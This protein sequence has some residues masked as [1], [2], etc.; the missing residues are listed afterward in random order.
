MGA[1]ADVWR[2]VRIDTCREGCPD[3]AAPSDI[4]TPLSVSAKLSPVPT[5][6][7]TYNASYWTCVT[8]PDHSEEDEHALGELF[9]Y[10]CGTFAACPALKVLE[11][12]A[13][14]HRNE[15]AQRLSTR[16]VQDLFA[17]RLLELN[18]SLTIADGLG[19]FL[20]QQ[21]FIEKWSVHW[22][23][24][25]FGVEPQVDSPL[26]H[27]ALPNVHTLWCSASQANHVLRIRE[28]IMRLE[29]TDVNFPSLHLLEHPYNSIR[30]LAFKAMAHY[31]DL[32]PCLIAAAQ[33]FSWHLHA[34][35]LL[36]QRRSFCCSTAFSGAQYSLLAGQL[37]FPP[38]FTAPQT[39]DDMVDEPP[40]EWT[41]KML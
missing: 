10:I 16:A 41:L 19:Q 18:S 38:G 29:L 1:R 26:H 9:D 8:R 30:H 32:E 34:S 17:C 36:A 3:N 21:P 13:R 23:R 28:I 25:R 39:P 27:N 4:G 37:R 33:K 2:G 11:I 12:M 15:L 40:E 35:E 14:H 6:R 24:P 7:R 20:L 22:L 5:A 31:D